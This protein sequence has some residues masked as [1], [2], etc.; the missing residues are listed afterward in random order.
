M[1]YSITEEK[2]KN[3]TDFIPE[4]QIDPIYQIHDN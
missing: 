2:E 1:L 4:I 3:Q